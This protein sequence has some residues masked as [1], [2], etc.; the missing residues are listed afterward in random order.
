MQFEVWGLGSGIWDLGEWGGGRGRGKFRA[1][2]RVGG[3]GW[4]RGP[5][6]ESSRSSVAEMAMHHHRRGT[7][8]FRN[9]CCW[10]YARNFIWAFL[11]GYSG[12]FCNEPTQS[13]IEVAE[14]SG[15]I[16]PTRKGAVLVFVPYLGSSNLLHPLTDIGC[17]RV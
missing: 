5:V 4:G 9:F 7:I 3:R 2:A 16:H 17:S 8:C 15:I 1:G 14:D 10:T 13:M 12:D 11:V 6:A